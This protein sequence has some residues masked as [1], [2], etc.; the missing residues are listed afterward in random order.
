MPGPAVQL[1]PF[2][3]AFPRRL[4]DLARPPILRIRGAMVEPARSIAIVGSRAATAVAC[5][6]AQALATHAARHGVQVVSGGA[7]GIDAAAHRGALA[8][9][10][11]T[12]VVLGTG[13]DIIYPD[14]H[15][16]L[17]A[18]VEAAGGALVTA[19]PDGT[20][21][22]P[23]H[24]VQRNELIAAL[25]D[26][27]I[28][29]SASAGSGALHTA[30]AACRLGRAL[31]ATPG[32]AGTRMLVAAGAS[33]V[34]T[35]DELDVV[36]AGGRLRPSRPAPSDDGRRVL[37]AIAGAT[38]PQTIDDLAEAGLGLPVGLLAALLSE[39]ESDGWIIPIP[40][41]AYVGAP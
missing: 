22:R 9:G 26:V 38:R 18:A 23:G 6:T 34:S 16:G 14:R 3:A 10:G 28:V 37:D 40:G 31:A 19:Y 20:P 33:P 4:R 15:R 12:V 30:R 39:L 8:G 41:G 2:D 11:H 13:L 36:L 29:V 35:P 32:T 24:F 21:P 25:A 27:V 17:F 1:S 7:I 5:G